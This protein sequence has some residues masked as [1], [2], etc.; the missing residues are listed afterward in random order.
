MDECE[1]RKCTGR[2]MERYGL[3]ASYTRK[4]KQAVLLTPFA[5]IAFSPADKEQCLRHGIAVIDCSWNK[6][7]ES[8]E[9]H[10]IPPHLQPLHNSS[11]THRL[12]PF[13]VPANPVHF[14]KP[15]I[16]STVEAVGAALWIIGKKELAREVLS[17]YTWGEKFLEMNL[18]LLE[19]YAECQNSEEVV[20]VQQEYL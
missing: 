18:E 17:I 12:L 20:K 13:L 5:Q 14:G 19:R 3:A 1:P 16:L 10:R 15:T 6:I 9:V 8:K 7:L 4:A 11:A 2:K